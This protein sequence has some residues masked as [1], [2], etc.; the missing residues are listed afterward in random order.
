[1]SCLLADLVERQLGF[2]GNKA[3]QD[4]CCR[5]NGVDQLRVFGVILGIDCHIYS[6]LF[7]IIPRAL[8]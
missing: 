1:M 3:F 6:S 7:A 2:L 4:G 5:D 8:P